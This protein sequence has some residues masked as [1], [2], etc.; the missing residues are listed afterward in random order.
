MSMMPIFRMRREAYVHGD[1]PAQAM[2]SGFRYTARVVAAAALI[3]TAVFS[4][5]IGSGE[6][7]I[8]LIGF[9]LAVAV[10]FDAFVVPL[11]L[12]PAGTEGEAL[13]RRASTPR[14][15]IAGK[16]RTL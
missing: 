15:G 7:A 9:G 5:L 14:S 10:L 2:I 3:M 12:V 13:S 1:S 11:A 4:G 16:D 6:S 8:K